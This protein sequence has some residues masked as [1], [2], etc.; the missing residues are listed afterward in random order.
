MDPNGSQYNIL[1]RVVAAQARREIAKLK[2]ELAA[3]NAQM[4][5]GAKG[6]AA[7]SVGPM[8]ATMRASASATTA[9]TSSATA[10]AN[11]MKSAG[12][13]SA[14]A[15]AST[16]KLAAAIAK[17]RVAEIRLNEVR[18]KGAKASSSQVAADA[19]LSAARNAAATAA[20]KA[21]VAEMRLAEL[22]AKK[23]VS[24]S[25]L[26]AAE[27]RVAQ[28]R[29]ASLVSTQRV[30]IAEMALAEAKVKGTASASTVAAAEERLILARRGVVGATV[31][32][33]TAQQGLTTA[34]TA[35]AVAESRLA[36]AGTLNRMRTL[37]ATT[38][39]A[40]KQ[41]S[42]FFTA[43]LL[44]AGAA[45]FKWQMD[46]EKAAAQLVKVYDNTSAEAN[47]AIQGIGG[48]F[49]GSPIDKF[50][51]A[52][53]EKMGIAKSEITE[54]GAAWAAVGATGKQL[55]NLTRLTSEAMVLGDLDQ[56][57]ATKALIAIQ[58][59]YKLSSQ[60]LEKTLWTLNATEN[61]TGASMGDL[62][63]AYSQTAAVAR[64]AGVDQAHLAAMIASLVPATGSAAKAGNGLKSIIS[65]FADP[66]TEK[67]TTA[68][69]QLAL[70]AGLA[71]DAFLNAQFKSQNMTQRLEQI[72]DVYGHLTGQAKVEFAKRVGGI[73][74]IS[75]AEQL[76]GDIFERNGDKLS[77]YGTALKNNNDA[78]EENSKATKTYQTYQKELQTVLESNPKKFQQV[79]QIIKN[80][81]TDVIIPL[82]P[83]I[84]WLAKSIAQLAKA[85]SELN[86][87]LQ[88]WI[89]IAL[90]AIALIGPISSL[91]GGF[92]LLAST[93][94]KAF[95]GMGK[96][97]SRLLFHFLGLR[98]GIYKTN[99][100]MAKST[101]FIK[102]LGNA[103]K[104]LFGIKSATD[105]A[106]TASTA[107]AQ[108]SQVALTTAGQTAQA[109]A[110]TTS[111]A[112]QTAAT[113][114]GQSAQLLAIEAG[115]VAQTRVFAVNQ[116]GIVTI[117]TGGVAAQQAALVA[118]QSSQLLALTA[119]QAAQGRVFVASQAGIV[120]TLR[121]S[122]AAQLAIVSA[123][124]AAIGSLWVASQTGQVAAISSS[125]TLVVA[126]ESATQ[127]ALF[128][129]V[130]VGSNNMGRVFVATQMGHI[131]IINAAR[132]QIVAA[133]VATNAALVAATRT[134]QSAQLA[135]V[136]A[137]QGAIVAASGAGGA[138]AAG[139]AAG[140]ATKAAAAKKSGV[141]TSLLS[142][143]AFIP[144]LGKYLAKAGTFL[145][146][147][148]GRV[149]SVGG[150]RAVVSGSK[151][152]GLFTGPIGWA[153]AGAITLIAMFPKQ[154][155]AALKAAWDK[156]WKIAGPIMG[157]DGIPILA[158]PFVA[159]VEVIKQ[160]LVALP[161][162]VV[163]VFKSVV[164]IINTAARKVYEAFSYINPFARHSPSLVENVTAGMEIVTN[165]F[166][167]ADKS[168]QGSM[169]N[170]YGAIARF[171]QATAGLNMDVESRQRAEKRNN[172][173]SIDPGALASWDE[174]VATEAELEQQLKRVNEQV[175]A[176]EAVVESAQAAVDAFDEQL[177]SM[178]DTLED[179]QD[180]IDAMGDVLDSLQEAAD[181]AADKLSE[182]QEKLDKFANAPI[183]GMRAME[184][185]IFANEMA[186]KKLQL[187]LLDMGSEGIDD[188]TDKFA[189]LQGQIETLSGQRN[190]LR[191]GGA[192]SDI[193]SV[194]DDQI[195]A[196]QA[197]QQAVDESLGPIQE[198]ENELKR[199]KT[200][201]ERLDLEKSLA[202]DPLQRQ[203]AQLADTTE[204][205]T[206][207][208]IT[209]GI[210][211]AR[212]EVSLWSTMVDG[213]NASVDAQQ[214]A[215]DAVTASMEA[216]QDQIDAVE[217]QREAAQ[218]NVDLEQEK[219]DLVKET[220]EQLDQTI[221]DL[222]TSMDE[223]N[224]SIDA[225]IQRHEEEA[226]AAEEAAREAERAAREAKEA[227]DALLGGGAEDFG[228]PGGSFQLGEELDLASIED[229]TKALTDEVEKSFGDID[230][231][232]PFKNAW[233]A[234]KDFFGRVWD[235]Y[236]WPGLIHIKD[237]F[238]T[239]MAELPGQL[240]SAI[241]YSIGFII[242][243]IGRI[244]FEA[245][246]TTLDVFMWLYDKFKSA[247]DSLVTWASD[248]NNWKDLA[249][250]IWNG[251]QKA[252]EWIFSGQ[253][254]IDLG[255]FG[256]QIIAGLLSGIWSAMK[257]IGT[258][259][260]DNMIVPF[261][262]GIKDGF[263]MHSP[264]RKM[265]EFGVDIIMGLLNGLLDAVTGVIT[266]F[267][268]LGGKVI[269][270]A[271]DI[272]AKL[273]EWMKAGWNWLRD[274]MP[275]NIQ[276]FMDWIAGVAGRIVDKLGDGKDALFDFGK[277]LVQGL[278]DGAGSLLS[279]IGE[280]FLEKLPGWI[281]EP[282]KKALGIQS[283]SKVF[284]GYGKNVGE[285]L[286]GGIDAM[287][288]QV[289]AATLAMADVVASTQFAAPELQQPLTT[290][291]ALLKVQ[292]PTTDVPSQ[293]AAD[294]AMAQ[295][296]WNTFG[297]AMA[298]MSAILNDAINAQIDD[299]STNTQLQFAVTSVNSQN[300]VLDMKN[301]VLTHATAMQD[302]MTATATLMR[303][304]VVNITT[305][306]TDQVTTQLA[307]LKDQGVLAM[308][309]TNDGVTDEFQAMSDN[310]NSIFTD[311]IQP[312]FNEF[313]PMLAQVGSWFE[314]TVTNI[315][316][317]WK[318][319]QE[320]VAVPARFVVNDVYN[321]GIKEA[322][323]KVSSWLGLENLPDFV[324]SF[325]TGGKVWGRGTETSDS[326]PARLSK[327]EHVITA[328]EVRGAG[329][330][331]AIEAQRAL[332]RSG[333]PAFASGIPAFAAG[334][335]VDL[336]APA[337]SGG[338]G[339][340]NLQPAAILARR[341]VH[342]YWPQIQTIGGYRASDPYP[343]H[344]SGL[345]LDI[346]TGD[347]IGTEVND[348]LHREMNA[349]AL[350]YTIW[351][352]MYKPAGG[353]ASM[354]EDRGSVTQN[355]YDHIHAL[356]NNNGVPG[357][358]A[359]GVGGG[360][361][362]IPYRDQVEKI[363]E[364]VMRPI[365]DSIPKGIPGGIGKLPQ[366]GFDKFHDDVKGFLLSKADE[367]DAMSS[368]F[369]A[370]GAGVERWRGT[371]QEVLRAMGLPSHWDNITLSQ[372]QIESGGDAQAI[373][374]T[375]SNAAKGTPSKGL[376]QV[377]DPTFDLMYSMFGPK[378][379][380]AKD[381]WNPHSNIAAGL[382]WA[383]HKYGGPEGAG[384]GQGHGY[385]SGGWLMP[386][387][388][389]AVNL[390]GKPEAV[391]TNE[392]WNAIY[393][394]ANNPLD[395]KG[396]AQG[397]ETGMKRTFGYTP[398]ENLSQEQAERVAEELDASQG[399]WQQNIY[400]ETKSQT[401]AVNDTTKAVKATEKGID[402]VAKVTS[403]VSAGV[404]KLSTIMLAVANAM[405]TAANGGQVTFAMIAP[406]LDGVADLIEML[407][408]AEATYV[409]WAGFDVVETE[410][411]K[412]QKAANDAANA[413]K[414][415]Y[416]VAKTVLPG[417]LRSVSTI[418][419]AIENLI[420]QDGAAWTSA[421]ALLSTGNPM[422]AILI[423]ALAVKAIF[424]ILPLILKAIVDIVPNLIKAIIKFMTDFAPD[425][426]YSYDTIDAAAEAVGKNEADI[427]S[428][429]YQ[430][431][432]EGTSIDAPVNQSTTMNFYGDIVL[433]NITSGD[434]AEEFSEN[435]Q[436]LSE[437]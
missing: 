120:A 405:Q 437:G 275:E 332:W 390:T 224:Q 7:T 182:A 423:I 213:A 78:F 356:F 141:I 288:P 11:A 240:M 268:E 71:G 249:S 64:S 210:R 238:V 45:A 77:Y 352:Q 3:I 338:G 267:S 290:D 281:K 93:V 214:A 183:K 164:S 291:P 343:D 368:S 60:D 111:Q 65:K 110:T 300:T 81:M 379:G 19:R 347:P 364:E 50:F 260:W 97:L 424:T 70:S 54:M 428:G 186:Q 168:I 21:S 239:W 109:T 301:G 367:K 167:D 261:F 398:V 4:A 331:Q 190:E 30:A 253:A 436:N 427:K 208:Q 361:A 317:Q 126:A 232:S 32:A 435:L 414:G 115:Q 137:G 434:Q 24:A 116:A 262:N 155:V 339:E 236:I 223:Y 406:V 376:M 85:F 342:K 163:A 51:T 345:A 333:T 397:V 162:I 48:E 197:Q 68:F 318:G 160:A 279:K 166:A 391:L 14:T 353:T 252:L 22:Q 254:I 92:V 16:D 294:T 171:G 233:Q 259:I 86:P 91:I 401:G 175:K 121:A 17:A 53:S 245:I 113:V 158:R 125:R 366:K 226:R 38:V 310:L 395:V 263:D 26:A 144:G 380:Y 413:A 156:I 248:I 289:E 145:K 69:E 40:G 136:T 314:D 79:G 176:Q 383:V 326:I 320:G 229:Q 266:F 178:N 280:F 203:I 212:A 237:N 195:A 188:A 365:R 152:L 192:G 150:L 340:S 246:D 66:D 219:L 388:T 82:I 308:Q 377:I 88:K 205:L 123:N 349:L 209:N 194:Y 35:G 243:A 415:S 2:A 119:G 28:T 96:V 148:I 403:Q 179:Y 387:Q 207:D 218:A 217:S 117:V 114:S 306:M 132:P 299:L 271:G 191:M 135:T 431:Q 131:A 189:Q 322:W 371:V 392:D 107:A 36:T 305:S 411:M 106:S 341:N 312:M 394:A 230:L 161:K 421:I 172:I 307:Q 335:P 316:T 102:K 80:S 201:A 151:I 27:A 293:V 396:V 313:D 90:V 385:D 370:A 165:E 47:A 112:A 269:D 146:A 130:R 15:A 42:M 357:I 381:V 1:I 118:G 34:Q 372:M 359:G 328:K 389:N 336:N 241:T 404:D 12:G 432:W 274:K 225:T 360:A 426:T 23:S 29:A 140:G 222:K 325:A 46:N 74:Q 72:A 124:Q 419:T 410:E 354:M 373:N 33:T 206:F 83:H 251:C 187:A 227:Q 62:I 276:G 100:E 18:M 221:Q 244:L 334:G 55:T 139:A 108:S 409:P 143:F 255:T 196:I 41:V 169:R 304:N 228:L 142:M 292:S 350:N 429:V 9:A 67:A 75:R 231:L 87:A 56:E 39:W 76:L 407:P 122:T 49:Q 295:Q 154:I 297:G 247:L 282:F 220:Y 6:N 258:W 44:L 216:Y 369:A 98:T 159:A 61:A 63:T 193:L 393:Q 127:A 323:N 324:A 287:V 420:A 309:G 382:Q 433:P 302:G 278:L 235:D 327:N 298:E 198:M 399:G 180:Q 351:K 330:H 57:E 315:G 270:A 59:Q 185:Q 8:A 25:T 105:V 363:F 199:L 89:V 422:G 303:D 321:K 13:A 103:W 170:A 416:M 211:S 10:Y 277:N 425:A 202:F 265:A 234:V 257:G 362:R 400:D 181:F 133:Q 386:G 418:G 285:G 375:D 264:S 153:I 417:I 272:G 134:G 37:G 52:L 147:N 104:W 58:A 215:I 355:H 73:F 149:F 31:A 99:A 329:G 129:V 408:D 256:F 174:M 344:P 273:A 204:E 138:A 84:L 200:E 43:P 430:Q 319:I 157:D 402:N 348:W 311:Q 296:T 5:K 378:T 173:A 283:P 242:G 128:N 101:P 384:W 20:A 412:R 284:A 374:L 286:V 184:D 177:D 250:S 95:V 346:M 337:W 358:Q 94:G